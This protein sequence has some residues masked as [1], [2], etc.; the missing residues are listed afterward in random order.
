VSTVL[1]NRFGKS[2]SSAPPALLSVG[3]IYCDL[4]FAGIDRMPTQ[5]TEIFANNLTICAGGGAF[6]TSAYFRA[7][8]G[9]SQVA[10]YLPAAPFDTPVLEQMTASHVGSHLC[11]RATE[12]A[13]PQVTVAMTLEHDRAFLTR[14]AGPAIPRLTAAQ[15]ANAG[16]GHLHIGEL[17]SLEEHPWLLD[18][19]R[20]AGITVSLDCGWDDDVGAKAGDLISEVDI[21]LPNKDE[22]QH[23]EDRKIAWSDKVLTVVKCG[24]EGAYA[25]SNGGMTASSAVPSKVVDT[26]G[27]GD[28]FNGGFLFGLLAGEP[29]EACLEKG[30]RCGS[31]A[32]SA[33]GGTGGTHLVAATP[34]ASVSREVSP[35]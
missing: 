20:D 29:L 1:E 24:R 8:G 34:V 4:V 22:R 5:G 11:Q 7:V 35:A 16:V 15:I 26:T 23:L 13:D 3:R 21:F 33:T 30:N 6:I 31:A 10:A 12:G 18:L 27:A 28:A 17:R 25:L 2:G 14:A 19:A 32:V 9:R